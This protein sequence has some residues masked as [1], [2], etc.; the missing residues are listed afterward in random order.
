MIRLSLILLATSLLSGCSLFGIRDNYE[1]TA[2]V[3]VD[4]LTDKVEIRRYERRLAVETTVNTKE[5]REGRNEA[6]R[7]LFKYISGDNETNEDIEMTAPVESKKVSEEISMT[8]P[9]ETSRT[10]T[11]GT[12]MRF[13]LPSDYTIETTPRPNNP[14]VRII[15]IDQQLQAVLSF[16]GITKE[17]IIKKNTDILLDTIV[18]STWQATGETMAYSYDPPWTIPFL[19]RNEVA[20]VVI[21]P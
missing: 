10:I 7:V 11:G 3:V 5:F 15:E 18:N 20:I 14:R 21:K 6:F 1:H 19:R 12:I 13:F 16:S 4:N 17:N 8:T 9:V 2:Y